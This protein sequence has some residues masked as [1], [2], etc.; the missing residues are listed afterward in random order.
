[1]AS[2]MNKNPLRRAK[3]SDD[4]KHRFQLSRIWD[5]D[6]PKV[7]F[8]MFNPSI[9]NEKND[10]PTTRRLIG[11]TKKFNYGGFLVGNLFTSITPF[12]K[13]IDTSIGISIKNL[14]IL[15]NMLL[16]VDQVIYAWGSSIEEPNEFK[17]FIS[18]PMCFGKN[19]NGTPKHPLYLSYNNKLV[20]Y[21]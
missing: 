2:N 15:K 7:L 3:L 19:L 17:K 5:D 6:K 21:R 1:M 14:N 9:A 11:F 4:R 20:D 8:I 10:D 12:P 18:N 13:D 16:E